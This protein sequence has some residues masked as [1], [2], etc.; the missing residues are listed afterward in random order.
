MEQRYLGITPYSENSDFEFAGRN[1]ETWALY[2][3]IARNDYTV[4][5]AS[6]GE[7]KSSLIRAGLIP[8]LRRR[9]YYPVYIVFDDKEFDNPLS[10]ERVLSDRI[11]NEGIQYEQSEWSKSLF[12][13][14]QSDV[15]KNYLWW[16]IRNYCF[17]RGEKELKPLFIFD[18]FEEVFTKASYEWTDSFF[19]QLEEISTDYVPKTMQANSSLGF[20]NIPTQKNYKALFSFR[21]EY[22]GDLD[23]WCVEKHFLPSLQENRMCL[24]PLT[25]KGAREVV[26]L[27]ESSLGRYADRIIKGCTEP[28][29]NIQSGSQPCVYAL[30]LS[31]VC[32]TLSDLPDNERDSVLNNLIYNQDG[33]IDD[34]LL[35]FY[36]KKLKEVNLDY[37]KDEK[38][39]DKIEKN[40]VDEKGKRSRRDTDE[41]SMREIS[42]WIEPLCENGLLKVIGK[43]VIN[44]IA[45]KTVE[46]PHDRLCKAIDTSR[47]ERHEKVEWQLNRQGEW[48]QFGIITVIVGII[49]F[50]W[51]TLIPK[52]N[53]VVH[54]FLS[55]PQNIWGKYCT[56]LSGKHVEYNSYSLDEGFSTISL[57][58]LLLIFVPLITIFI[59]HINRKQQ[60]AVFALSMIG[61]LSLGWLL[62]R[63]NSIQFTTNYVYIFTVIGFF[64]CCFGLVF[65]S[66]KLRS[67]F[68]NRN[69]VEEKKPM[70]I[71]PLSGGYFLFGCYA[72]YE[73]L[74]RTSFG[75]NEPCDS[76]WALMVLPMFYSIWAW[77]Y[78][79]MAIET[80][81]KKLLWIYVIASIIILLS[82]TIISFIPYNNIFKNRYGFIISVILILVW[83]S[84]SV[85]ILRHVKSNTKFLKLKTINRISIALIGGIIITT[86]FIMNLGFNPLAISPSS[87]CHVSSW[88]DVLVSQ[89]DSLGNKRMGI[90]YSSNG[91][92]IVPFCI[93]ADTNKD[94]LL[95]KGILPF[96]SS[97]IPI[98][99]PSEGFAIADDFTSNADNTFIRNYET[100]TGY[101]P[102]VSTLEEYLHNMELAVPEK[103]DRGGLIDYYSASL[104]KEIRDAN[105]DYL[106]TG[107]PYGIEA[108]K[109]FKTLDSLQCEALD[110]ELKKLSANPIDT[111]IASNGWHMLRKHV[112][113]LEDKHLVDFHKE[114]T[115][116][117]LLCV[118]KD[119][120]NCSDMPSM[121]SIATIFELAYF[122]D[123]PSMDVDNHFEVNQFVTYNKIVG[124][125][126]IQKI[127]KREIRYS[128]Y[129]DDILN[130]RIFAWYDLFHSLCWL[131]IG[132]NMKEYAMR[133]TSYLNKLEEYMKI[134]K[135]TYKDIS[136]ALNV[137]EKPSAEFLTEVISMFDTISSYTPIKEKLEE[138]F[139]VYDP[140]YYESILER[141][142]SID[143][144]YNNAEI[145]KS[146]QQL[147]AGV[148]H[149]L[150]P[151]MKT[152]QTGI[153][154][155]VFES[156]CK[157]LILVS[158]CRGNDVND[159]MNDFSNYLD[160]KN[161]FY[162]IV[163]EMS[164][165]IGVLS[166][167][168][169]NKDALEKQLKRV[170]ENMKKKDNN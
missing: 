141:M 126:T 15:L 154:N 148:L 145:D 38:T 10:L 103:R 55:S 43:K 51:N 112:E 3:R 74:F 152:Y 97:R 83:L 45:V 160:D 155:N 44:G 46:L 102:V 54:G 153:Y 99:V 65:S 130:G 123:V 8:I 110:L 12:N 158:A 42:D 64:F 108:L 29:S 68:M 73:F 122:V 146:L 5:Y 50:L 35:R 100:I 49:A 151:I 27:N 147:K 33:T 52:L 30:I 60:I 80:G 125:D 94:T 116:S 163:E 159:D 106:L 24:K 157:S 31:V 156:V 93:M 9:D 167:T 114:L 75:I 170:I 59:T 28:K 7:G 129:S 32:Q 101:V 72:F 70:S 134:E 58:I 113:I 76:S 89:N 19:S 20:I 41:S 162:Y 62:I 84:Y 135:D 109:S 132:L 81:S 140:E 88:R 164:N 139:Q 168:K 105:I 107:K 79:C 67:I 1:D 91:K 4:Y 56:F 92:T 96:K 11:N 82:L 25:P 169:K 95:S 143:I 85:M 40:L 47:K 77:D 137:L 115:R 150:L 161:N 21:T 127:D 13:A 98:I 57:M 128:V 119:R 142:T 48:I 131:D 14:E 69:K 61:T 166:Y 16:R 37:L 39:I 117:F 149:T 17:K 133:I 22:L 138:Y 2:D 87:V 71:W 6:S 124:N 63:N 36:R 53:V 66:I 78:S 104:F 86:T 111:T 18:Q 26:A 165:D 144:Q 136:K 118:I 120:V 34:I 121:F 23:Y 90:V